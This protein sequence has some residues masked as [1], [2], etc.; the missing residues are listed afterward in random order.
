LLHEPVVVVEANEDVDIA[1][2]PFLS[3][4]NAAK[5]KRLR[6]A[7]ALEQRNELS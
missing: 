7:R 4:R 3:P 1:L 2:W 6:N 5:Q